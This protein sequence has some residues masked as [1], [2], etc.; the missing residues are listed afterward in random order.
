MKDVAFE[1][2]CPYCGKVNTKAGSVDNKVVT[3]KEGDVTL[4]IDCGNLAI[5]QASAPGGMKRISSH[6]ELVE[7]CTLNPPLIAALRAWWAVKREKGVH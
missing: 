2:T 4:C 5:I 7:M 3:P 1:C 6:A